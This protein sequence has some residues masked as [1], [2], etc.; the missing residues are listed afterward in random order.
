VRNKANWADGASKETPCGVTTSASRC[1]KQSQFPGSVKLEAGSV[2]G[3]EVCGESSHWTALLHL[4]KRSQFRRNCLS[5]KGL[6]ERRWAAKTGPVRR[7]V[8]RCVVRTLRIMLGGSY[9]SWGALGPRYKRSQLARGDAHPTGSY[10]AKQSQLQ[11]SVKFEVARVRGTEARGKSSE[12]TAL[13]RLYERS[14]F[15]R[16][17]LSCKGL[18]ERRLPVE[19]GPVRRVEL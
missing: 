2:K 1:A 15:G 6:G 18:G 17:C 14:Q 19:A 9:P 11:R 3:T 13:S 8:E 5:R 10:R 16:N 7:G 12:W 4:Y